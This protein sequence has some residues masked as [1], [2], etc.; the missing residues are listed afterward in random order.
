MYGVDTFDAI[1]PPG[2]GAILAVGA[3][4]RTVV[5]IGDAIGVRSVMTLNLTADHRHINGDK[6]AE[7][8]QTLKATIEAPDNLIM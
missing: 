5:P 2:Q 1:L 6:A 4:K 7:F 8:M 3:S